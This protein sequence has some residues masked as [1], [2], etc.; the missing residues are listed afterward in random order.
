MSSIVDINTS[1]ARDNL[2]RPKLTQ[3]SASN[4][5]Y[6]FPINTPANL[7]SSDRSKDSYISSLEKQLAEAKESCSKLDSKNE[8]QSHVIASMKQMISSTIKSEDQYLKVAIRKNVSNII[9]N[10]LGKII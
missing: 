6:S 3:N 9:L 5:G 10:F 2:V 4:I 8:E 1:E 7:F